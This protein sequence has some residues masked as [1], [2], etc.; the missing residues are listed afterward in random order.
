MATYYIGV[1][2][3]F[4]NHR[5]PIAGTAY[6]TKTRNP[7]PSGELV[8]GGISSSSF[9][10]QEHIVLEG[11]LSPGFGTLSVKGGGD[12]K[13]TM[14]GIFKNSGLDRFCGAQGL[15]DAKQLRYDQPVKIAVS[16]GDMIYL[17][18]TTF[19]DNY[20]M[21]YEFETTAYDIREYVSR[22]P[23]P[24]TGRGPGISLP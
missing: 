3:V 9:D 23:P 10:G 12:G 16:P 19:D 22:P 13:K 17:V 20:H 5:F 1:P 8:D 18:Q 2:S 11:L 21:Y 6:L 14:E 15:N 7:V 4:T 24:H